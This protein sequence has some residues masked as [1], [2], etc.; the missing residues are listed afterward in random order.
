MLKVSIA[1]RLTTS[2]LA[3]YVDMYKPTEDRRSPSSTKR[4]TPDE[5]KPSYR[6]SKW[7]H[8]ASMWTTNPSRLVEN[9]VFPLL[10]GSK[11]HLTS[12]TD[13]RTSRCDHQP[14]AS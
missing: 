1:T 7:K 5:D 12:R 10:M 2:A 13:L 14:T 3:P 9:N 8:L 6:P 4:P 11:S